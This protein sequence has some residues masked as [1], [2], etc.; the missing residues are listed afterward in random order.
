METFQLNNP[1]K[2]ELISDI[3]TF[4]NRSFSK[5]LCF[6]NLNLMNGVWNICLSD[7]KCIWLGNPNDLSQVNEFIIVSTSFVN[8]FRFKTSGGQESYF[9]IIQS[10]LVQLSKNDSK[11]FITFEPHR[12]FTINSPSNKIYL[13]FSFYPERKFNERTFPKM[14]MEATLLFYRMK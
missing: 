10:F 3:L 5:E 4:E 6:Q 14:Q 9:P 7:I 12:W 2:S 1:I 13:N 8:G 11:K